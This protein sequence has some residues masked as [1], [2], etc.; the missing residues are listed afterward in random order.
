[1]QITR[2]EGL[3]LYNLFYFAVDALY[4][5]EQKTTFLP[6]L[7]QVGIYLPLLIGL[8]L[9]YPC[10]E[11]LK[12]SLNTHKVKDDNEN[13]LLIPSNSQEKCYRNSDTK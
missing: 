6:M 11:R 7:V 9:L 5:Y 4:E 2:P 13:K 8:L 12:K 3:G 1:M 10:F